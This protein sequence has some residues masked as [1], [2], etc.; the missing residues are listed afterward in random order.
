LPPSQDIVEIAIASGFSKLAAALTEA[1]LVS[2]LQGEGPFTVFAPTDAAFDE[3]YSALGVDGPG[4]V[5]Q[6]TLQAV[7]LYHVIGARVF[8]TDLENG[9]EPVTV[10]GES[11]TVNVGE[12]SVTISD[13]ANSDPDAVVTNVNILGT[14]GVIH[15]INKVILPPTN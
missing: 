5:P 6:A 4:E 8:S 3:L 13:G 15:V 10:G 1:G 7:L 9:L 11:F 12:T 14:N 2:T